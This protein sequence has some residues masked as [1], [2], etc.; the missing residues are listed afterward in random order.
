MVRTHRL[1]KAKCFLSATKCYPGK[2]NILA[3]EVCDCEFC[4]DSFAANLSPGLEAGEHA[5][6]WQP[7]AAAKDLRLWLL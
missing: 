6:G 7:G 2:K 3:E 5:I 1:V 4:L